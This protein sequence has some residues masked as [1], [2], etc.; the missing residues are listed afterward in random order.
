MAK[1]SLAQIKALYNKLSS[2]K[3]KIKLPKSKFGSFKVKKIKLG[4]F[5]YR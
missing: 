1:K 4:K 2:A 3:I 5:T